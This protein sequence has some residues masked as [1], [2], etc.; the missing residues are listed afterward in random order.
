MFAKL[1]NGFS[2]A[3]TDT[4][5]DSTSPNPVLRGRG[6][7]SATKKSRTRKAHASAT[8]TRTQADR[9]DAVCAIS[10]PPKSGAVATLKPPIAVRDLYSSKG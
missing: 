8:A 5:F 2:E 4:G 1:A 10:K 3:T 9:A 6:R 7:V